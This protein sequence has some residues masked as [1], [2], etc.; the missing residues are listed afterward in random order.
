MKKT[1]YLQVVKLENDEFDFAALTPDTAEEMS[2]LIECLST[3]VAMVA[4]RAARDTRFACHSG[5]TFA[6]LIERS[7]RKFHDADP[8]EYHRI[9]ESGMLQRAVST[10]TG[11]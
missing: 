5:C 8:E 6:A 9:I 7:H 4:R 2:E 10:G 3:L 1:P 11:H